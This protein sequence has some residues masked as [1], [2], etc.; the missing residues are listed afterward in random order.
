[1]K[2]KAKIWLVLA[3][4]ISLVLVIDLALAWNNLEEK[5]REEAT[6][7]ARS[8][9]GFMMSTRRIYQKQFIDSGLPVNNKTIG[10]LP[11][12]S[13]TLIS[14]DFSNWNKSGVRFNNV[15]DVPRNP[16]N[17]ADS[18]ELAAMT[19]FREHPD[20]REQVVDILD[21]DGKDYMLFTAPIWMEPFCLK[22][23]G[24]REDAPESI[25]DTYADS[26]DY[27]VGDLRGV[28][29]IRIPTEK[30]QENYRE[31]WRK[32]VA[33]S[34]VGYLAIFLVLGFL[35]DRLVLRRLTTIGDLTKRIALG[36][37]SARVKPRGR[38]EIASLADSFNVMVAEVERHAIHVHKLAY[39]DGLTGLPNRTLL[40]DRIQQLLATDQGRDQIEALI[41]INPDRFRTINDA[42]GHN[43]GDEVL[44]A[45]AR[46]LEESLQE[47]D[48]LARMSADEFALL[49]PNAGRQPE[50]AIAHALGVAQEIHSAFERPLC[51]AK[52]EIFLTLS[53]GITIFPEVVHEQIQDVLRRADTALHRAKAAGGNQ[54]ACFETGM[55]ESAEK[56][57]LIERELRQAIVEDQLRLF[58]QPQV[59]AAGQPVGAEVLVRW[60]HPEKGLLGPFAFIPIA[61]ESD[62]IVD[63]G[64]WVLIE[65]F[66]ILPRLKC[67]DTALRLS[68]NISPR[69]FCRAGFVD[70]VCDVLKATEADPTRIT[71]EITESL[72]MDNIEEVIAR[73][74]KLVACGFH[75]AIDDFGTGYSSLGYLK[76]LPI[77]EIKI[78]KG[79][80]QDAPTDA[81]DGMLVETI[82]SVAKHMQLRVVAEGVETKEQA[83][84][85][86]ARAEVIHQGYL[87]G[88][89][90]PAEDWISRWEQMG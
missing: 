82:L 49:I 32:Q 54:I 23:H 19:V 5:V 59:D 81:K 2:L 71:L 20:R 52:E 42:R 88:R 69:Q 56:R 37:Y 26:Y 67:G 12:H 4:L 53:L 33:K 43:T 1:M 83:D 36:D 8:I 38:D 72:V 27:K 41:L 24:R 63:L 55:G 89:P 74:T 46:R 60:Q 22:C 17:Q 11:A 39:Y 50:Q 44:K 31:I 87:Y 28:V 77:E 47:G 79:F 9:Y 16:D 73:M 6:F 40:F 30:L 35:L 85:L 62:L 61:E 14:K 64:A 65:S 45:C 58:L 76:R 75:F 15:S 57:F 51:L 10:F 84:F 13:F 78:D 70:W 90:E 80:I 68:I 29:S 66:R 48:T 25:R 34:L 7:N 18:F 3:G 86:N 21:T